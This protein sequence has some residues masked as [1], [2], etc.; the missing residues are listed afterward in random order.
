MG[1][2]LDIITN[3]VGY[4]PAL[5]RMLQMLS[6][7]I[8]ILMVMG[9][10]RGASKR[11]DLGPSSGSWSAPA[12]MLVIGAC[13]I[14]LPGLMA[15][16]TQTFFRQASPS[17]SQIFEYA[18]TTVGMMEDGGA[19]QTMIQ[20]ITAVVMF[21]GVIAVMRGLYL[22]NQSAGG[23]QGPKTF[24]PGATF[25]ISGVMAFNFPLFVGAMEL[26]LNGASSGG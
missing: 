12:W 20:G 23:A 8:G 25:L 16:L 3:L 15:T 11:S 14:A 24:G 26:L 4:L 17:A 5:D 21:I 9:A 13:F 19:A 7:V 2:L 18:P 10:I 6:W 1:N 22:L